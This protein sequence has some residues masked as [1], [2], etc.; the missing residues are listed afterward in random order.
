M[1]TVSVAP[2]PYLSLLGLRG[3]SI[4]LNGKIVCRCKSEREEA[5]YEL[6]VLALT[7][8]FKHLYWI[9]ILNSG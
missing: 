6:I 9:L 1:P 3:W 5:P 8:E 4:D 2:F 7:H